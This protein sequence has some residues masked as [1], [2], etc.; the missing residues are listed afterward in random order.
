MNVSI[1]NDVLISVSLSVA[2][3]IAELLRRFPFCKPM[4]HVLQQDL[5]VVNSK[6]TCDKCSKAPDESHF[7]C[8]CAWVGVCCV[9]RN[10]RHLVFIWIYFDL[11]PITDVN[12]KLTRRVL[13]M[14]KT[15]N[16]NLVK[17]E[18]GNGKMWHQVRGQIDQN[19]WMVDFWAVE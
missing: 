7:M 11:C 10:K 15:R 12:I 3:S 5:Y 6:T 2:Y 4:L 17:I 16:K 19:F 18:K 8:V 14:P 9:H 13:C 1:A